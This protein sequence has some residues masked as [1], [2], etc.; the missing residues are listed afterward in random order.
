MPFQG[1]P[2]MASLQTEVLTGMLLEDNERLKIL[3]PAEWQ[4]RSSRLKEVAGVRAP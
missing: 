3:D 4:E 1:E 2:Q